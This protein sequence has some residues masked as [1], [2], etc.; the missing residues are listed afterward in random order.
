MPYPQCN[1][2]GPIGTRVRLSYVPG[3]PGRRIPAVSRSASSNHRHR[4]GTVQSRT[5][6]RMMAIPA[7]VPALFLAVF[8]SGCPA[9]N[10]PASSRLEIRFGFDIMENPG[11]KGAGRMAPRIVKPDDSWMP[12]K[13]F[14]TGNGPAGEVFEREVSGTSLS[15]DLAPGEWTIRVDALN[16]QSKTVAS[17]SSTVTLGAGRRTQIAIELRPVEGTGLVILSFTRNYPAMP[18]GR[19]TGRLEPRVDSSFT[20]GTTGGLQPILIDIPGNSETLEL[21]QVAAGYY[22]LTL[23]IEDGQG[24]IGGLADTVLVLSGFE[25]RGTCVFELGAPEFD[26]DLSLDPVDPLEE[27]VLFARTTVNRS[28]PFTATS[29]GTL[30]DQVL[31]WFVNGRA[32]PGVVVPGTAGGIPGMRQYSV[33]VLD[34]GLLPS[35]V[36]IDTITRDPVSGRC[37]AGTSTVD[38]ISGPVSGGWAWR[39]KYSHTAATG[40]S[41]HGKG[42]IDNSGSGESRSVRAIAAAGS[43]GITLVAGLDADAAIHAFHPDG[44]GGLIRL[45]REI[46]KVNGTTRTVDRLAVAA[47][48]RAA[49]AANSS[50]TWLR[51]YLT[52]ASGAIRSTHDFLGVKNTTMDFSSIRSLV[53]S[54]DSRRLY[55][56]ANSPEAVFVFDIDHE[57]GGTCSLEERIDLQALRSG[58]SSMSVQDID[59]SQDGTVCVSASG[60]SRLLLFTRIAEAHTLVQSIDRAFAGASMYKPGSLRMTAD[61]KHLYVLCD[62]SRIAHFSRESTSVSFGAPAFVALPSAA[63]DAVSLAIGCTS[64]DGGS[65]EAKDVVAITGGAAIALFDREASTGSLGS[66]V[67]IH[68]GAVE[69]Y[70]IRDALDSSFAGSSLLVAGGMSASFGIV[71]PVP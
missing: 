26:V 10:G 70:G 31:E 11:G 38:F 59:I 57:E 44:S 67:S 47:D 12:S 13:Y 69:S 64:H 17:G 45:W 49:A 5:R 62:G 63:T 39:S 28:L 30:N 43:R 24:T 2:N 56:L 8:L 37:G 15:L 14:I 19:I 21:G 34:P 41:I 18:G 61:G 36:R 32:S 29:M 60:E 54:A 33:E 68:A 25:T 9:P 16:D 48:G 7:I 4:P 1:A 6:R 3:C 58:T 66:P 65:T 50:S 53:F 52:D 20:G 55:V 35:R 42:R 23:T 27:P 40:P 46:V 51:I 22:L 71:S